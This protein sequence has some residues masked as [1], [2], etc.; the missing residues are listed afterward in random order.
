MATTRARGHFALSPGNTMADV[1][2]PPSRRP[3]LRPEGS[4]EVTVKIYDVT[5]PFDHD[6]RRTVRLMLGAGS[7]SQTERG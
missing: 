3:I 2:P 7:D 5:V 4:L 1:R 6:T